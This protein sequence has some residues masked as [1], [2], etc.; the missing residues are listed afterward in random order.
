MCPRDKHKGEEQDARVGQRGVDDV[1]RPEG[2]GVDG[3]F[4]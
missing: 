2:V 4:I 1:E 3:V